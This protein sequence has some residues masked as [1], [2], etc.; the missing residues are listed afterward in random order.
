MPRKYAIL[1]LL[2]VAASGCPDVYAGDFVTRAAGSYA[3]AG[4]DSAAR[5]G[6]VVAPEAACDSDRSVVRTPD[7]DAMPATTTRRATHV[8]ADDVGGGAHAA[9]APAA[10]GDDKPAPA[11]PHKA[12]ALRWQSLLPGVMK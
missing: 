8:G 9:L 11:S 12:R 6:R 10:S 3:P 2:L 4:D 7:T 5:A 1:A